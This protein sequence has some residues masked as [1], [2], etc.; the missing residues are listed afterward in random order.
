[1][2]ASPSAPPPSR[3]T[4]MVGLRLGGVLT[5]AMGL[6]FPAGPETDPEI[7]W[8]CAIEKERNRN[9]KPHPRQPRSITGSVATRF[10]RTQGAQERASVAHPTA[11]HKGRYILVAWAPPPAVLEVDF[12]VCKSSEGLLPW[13]LSLLKL[14]LAFQRRGTRTA[15]I[16][17]RP[18]FCI[19][20]CF[21][22]SVVGN[23]LAP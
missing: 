13:T 7:G 5:C 4:P 2:C 6:E 3:A 12:C 22:K 21:G 9:T 17:K 18:R 20:A 19:I 14:P 1:M 8:S 11:G 23:S 15:R 10:S 16:A